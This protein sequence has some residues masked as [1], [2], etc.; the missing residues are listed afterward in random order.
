MSTTHL[1]DRTARLATVVGKLPQ[2]QAIASE[3]FLGEISVAMEDD[4]EIEGKQYVV[5]QVQERQP[6]EWIAARRKEWYHLTHK[7]LGQDCEFV[8]LAITVV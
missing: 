8:Q 2:L 4:P 5:I 7:L 6:I 3:L 1:V